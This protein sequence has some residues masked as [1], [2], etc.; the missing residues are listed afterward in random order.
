MKQQGYP[1]DPYGFVCTEFER[2]VRDLT[3]HFSVEANELI[4][5]ELFL[6][7]WY[8]GYRG[9]KIIKALMPVLQQPFLLDLS[10]TSSNV[11]MH[12]GILHYLRNSIAQYSDCR[13]R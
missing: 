5:A 11:W 13:K 4:H 6:F 1:D 2:D 12:I 9:E 10:N 7:N 3:R 8:L